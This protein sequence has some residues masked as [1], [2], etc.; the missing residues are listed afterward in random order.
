MK[1]W[2]SALLVAFGLGLTVESLAQCQGKSGEQTAAVAASDKGKSGCNPA[3]CAAACKDKKGCDPAACGG[4]AVAAGMPRMQY[5]VGDQT[6]CC[7]GKADELAKGDAAKIRFVVADKEYTDKAEAMKAYQGELDSFLGT[8]TTVR[9][10][11]G[12]ECVACPNAAQQM[13]REKGE[14]V[15]FRVASYTYA[16][17]PAAEKAAKAASEAAEQVTMKTVVDGKTYTCEKEAT[18][19]AKTGGTCHGH[20]DAQTTAGKSDAKGETGKGTE[21]VIGETKTCCPV[22]AKVELAKAKINAAVAAI[23]KVNGTD[24]AAGDKPTGA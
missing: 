21:Y 6:L 19:A 10:A 7:T 13:A 15:K 20:G 24:V 8:L 9:Y 22:T 16:D 14:N 12:K 5:K 17:R 23:E 1:A 2:C 3:A 4:K 18:A 11:V